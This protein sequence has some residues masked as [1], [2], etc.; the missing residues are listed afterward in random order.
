MKVYI[1]ASDYEVYTEKNIN[2]KIIQRVEDDN[3]EGVLSY[4]K[5]HFSESEIFAMLPSSIQSE[6]F[7]NFKKSI[8]S[9][10]FH[11]RELDD[12]LCPQSKCPCTK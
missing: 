10:N 6:I 8:I 4:I 3:Y 7:E 2:E 12:A 1:D 11:T 9:M 5:A